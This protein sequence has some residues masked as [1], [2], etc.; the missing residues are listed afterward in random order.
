M[1]PAAAPTLAA[2]TADIGVPANGDFVYYIGSGPQHEHDV[3]RHACELGV[4]AFIVSIDIT[5]AGQL[6]N[7][8][9]RP[10][11]ASMLA[12]A[13][14]DRCRGA[15]VSIRCKSWS[16]AH[17]MPKPDGTPGTALRSF[18][19]SIE[20]IPR[21]DGTLPRSVMEGNIETEHI[22]EVCHTIAKHGGFLL[23]EMPTRRRAGSTLP[24]HLALEGYEKHA[25]MLDHPA[26]VRL[27]EAIGAKEIAWDQCP[28]ADVA[29]DSF[30]KA[31]IWLA[32]PNIFPI[33]HSLFGG[34][35][36]YH[37]KGTHRQL[38]GVDADGRFRTAATKNYSSGT[39]RLLARRVQWF[40]SGTV[41]GVCESKYT[42]MPP[43]MTESEWDDAQDALEAITLPARAHA[44][45][46][47]H[48]SFAT[49]AP[50]PDPPL[51]HDW[52]DLAT[53]REQAGHVDPHHVDLA[54]HRVAL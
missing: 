24:P 1:S 15:I 30:I 53:H 52:G 4:E 31:S 26:W 5:V 50:T 32:T 14:L 47:R 41:A 35:Q 10:T 29:E 21:A 27:K 34:L 16:A 18:P 37:P 33:M 51:R 9:K 43:F 6:H 7:I 11:I 12:G 20:G 38:K 39:N 2:T 49:P 19:D 36:C 3:A 40:L 44:T 23:V 22:T 8:L 17:L 42:D 48:V 28:L 46:A 45:P 25:H 54:T 13:R